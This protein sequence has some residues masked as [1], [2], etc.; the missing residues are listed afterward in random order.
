MN[1][2]LRK[3]FIGL[4]SLGGLLAVY[5]L[6]S[7]MSE[8][9]QIDMG[10]GG[11]FTDMV[12]ESNVGE[13][14]G[15]IG[16]IGDVEVIALK[17]PKFLHRNRN[18]EVDRELGF[19]ELLYEIEDNWEVRK[20]YLNVYQPSFKCYVTADRGR[21]QVE[22]AAGRHSPKDATFTGNVVAH[23][24]PAKGSNV[25][26]SFI[27]LDDVVFISGKSL[28]STAGP[29]R[30]ISQD[31]QMLGTGLELIY[32]DELDRLEFFRMI[33][34]DSL[35]LRSSQMPSL[36]SARMEIGQSADTASPTKTQQQVQSPNSK[37]TEQVPATTQ[38]KVK[39]GEGDYYR[40]VFG[41][42]VVI[43]APDQL[44]FADENISINDIFWSKG[45]TRKSSEAE[46][47]GTNDVE[48]PNIPV[49]KH[50]T[51]NELSDGQLVDTLIT[52]DD[53]VIVTPM[54]A[55][56][57]QRDSNE[58]D[59]KVIVPDRKK[60][61][62]FDAAWKTMFI[63]RNIDYSVSA[64]DAVGKGPLE[65]TFYSED[66]IG[67]EP[68]DTIVPVKV[69]AQKEAKFLSAPNQVIFEGDCLCT[70]LQNDPNIQQKYTLSAP[71]L[72]V[73]LGVHIKH[74]TADGGQVKL[75]TVKTAGKELL[76]GIELE[77][78]WFDY[79]VGQQLFLATG[80]GMIGLNNSRV[81]D[82]DEQVDRF[83]L[84]R[85]C[86]AFLRDFETLKY[87]LEAGR[88]IAD[89]EPQGTLRVDYIPVVEGQF[90]QQVIA[91]ASHVEV[92]L[93]QTADGQME[94]STLTASGGITYEDG[95]NEFA[96]SE[97]FY[98]HDKSI[99][100]IRGDRSQPCHYNDVLV[101]KIDYDLKTGKV[102][103]QVVGP[104]ALQ[105][106]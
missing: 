69:T 35:R 7:Q 80:P 22:T 13:F 105:I 5:L 66:V 19:E 50:S 97:L 56:R 41:K 47:A 73:T 57:V 34:L 17:K 11:E 1:S 30:F 36:S 20:P 85:S 54:S 70:M 89:A 43:D 62:D 58:L 84:R 79:D 67:A 46:A 81:P 29:V 55:A 40:C 99:M 45:T 28:F 95:A 86:Y 76:G 38:L 10:M 14:G 87:F 3:C 2:N 59:L 42:N 106:E 26:E 92:N 23:I 39:Q 90:G 74:L 91:T 100:K 24:L 18:K 83:S 82:P 72:T 44:I 60:L 9:P 31:A 64:G 49:T 96:G 48:V 37:K 102:K 78:R 75:A 8:T 68:N 77:C 93:V 98:D 27:Y 52:C 65:L 33:R 4:I 12:A 25:K 51:L 6:Y 101:D 104:G 63:A 61:E 103:F 71:K 88:I 21:V 15:E 16:K 94:L 53:G 32:N